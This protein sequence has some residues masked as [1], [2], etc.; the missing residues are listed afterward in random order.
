MSEGVV[1]GPHGADLEAIDKVAIFKPGT[2]LELSNGDLYQ[3]VSFS[4][5]KDA[6]KLY[7]VDAASAATD[8]VTTTIA[9]AA[10]IELGVFKAATGAA[11]YGWIQRA[12]NFP[13]IELNS[14][15]G[16]NV[17]LFTGTTAGRASA[18][19]KL[20][21][22]LKNIQDQATSAGDKKKCFSGEAIRVPTDA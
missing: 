22:A 5:A 19:G 18:S 1:K 15:V 3:Y 2:Q 21:H 10:P 14:A 13:E 4:A 16:A 7:V 17:E 8:A 20:I 9:E 12:G 6:A 11:G